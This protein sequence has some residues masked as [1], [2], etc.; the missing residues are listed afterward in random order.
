MRKVLP[1]EYPPIAT[2]PNTAS[3]FS[4]LWARKDETLPWFCDRFIQLAVKCNDFTDLWANFYDCTIANNYFVVNSCPYCDSLRMDRTTL[5]R[6]LDQF[7]DFI[8]YQIDRGYY[9]FATLDQYYLSCSKNYRQYHL[10]HTAFITGYDRQKNEIMLADFYDGSIP[11]TH[12]GVGGKYSF[13]TVTYNEI[14]DSYSKN[15]PKDG[16]PRYYSFL[17]LYK[18]VGY[19]YNFQLELMRLSLEDYVGCKDTFLKL[20]FH[21]ITELFLS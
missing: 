7:S 8:E 14:N 12:V 2:Y 5:N 17:T 6:S 19:D 1:V 4:I 3:L 21:S 18:Y 20:K 9:I 11:N 16:D 15:P 10:M 13:R